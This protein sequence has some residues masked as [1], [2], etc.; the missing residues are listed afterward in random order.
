MMISGSP[1]CFGKVGALQH[2]LGHGHRLA[3][4]FLAAAA[5]ENVGE[6]GDD[7]VGRQRREIR[8]CSF[9]GLLPGRFHRGKR[10]EQAVLVGV[11]ALEPAL[12]RAGIAFS[13]MQHARVVDDEDF[14]PAKA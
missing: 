5:L 9:G 1:G 7:R 4:I 14:R 12:A 3:Q 10:G 13:R 2:V 8:L 11:A 6:E